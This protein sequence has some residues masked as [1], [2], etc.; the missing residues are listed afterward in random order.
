VL[1]AFGIKDSFG[2]VLFCFFLCFCSCW[3]WGRGVIETGS[4]YVIQA[5]LELMEILPS[6][7]SKYWGDK[8]G[9]PHLALF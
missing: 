6:H 7:P 9:L 4:N 8:N 5:D 3:L 2:L 1:L